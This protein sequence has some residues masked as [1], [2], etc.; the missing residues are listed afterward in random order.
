MVVRKK[1]LNRCLV[2]TRAP[3]SGEHCVGMGIC[4]PLPQQHP[5]KTP[6]PKEIKRLAKSYCPDSVRGPISETALIKVCFYHVFP[7]VTA[8]YSVI[9]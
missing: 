5:A 2:F 8:T 1:L 6:S 7:I 3:G 4:Q 9:G